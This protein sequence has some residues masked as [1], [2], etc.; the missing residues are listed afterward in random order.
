M[1]VVWTDE[2]SQDR[3]EIL[4]YIEAHNPAAA[5]RMDKLF[6]SAAETLSHSPRIGH[7]GVIADTHEWKPHRNYR[8][9]YEIV[10]ETVIILVLIHAAR[11]WPPLQD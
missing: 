10:G 5:L 11:R 8:L 4:Q 6:S 3:L 9:V 2:A 1:K 7:P